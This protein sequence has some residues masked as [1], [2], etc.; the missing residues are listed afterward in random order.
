M[1]IGWIIV[2]I[3]L[4]A[5]VTALVAGTSVLVPLRLHRLALAADLQNVTTTTLS[6]T[7]KPER[8]AA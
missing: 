2:N 1:T 4:A 5:M 3:A 7:P 8:Q 6:R